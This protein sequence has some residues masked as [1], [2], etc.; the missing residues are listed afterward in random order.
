MSYGIYK[1]ALK[2][3][4]E[5]FR[6]SFYHAKK[7]ITVGSY[8]DEKAA[9]T[10]LKEALA[11]YDDPA[12]T[13]ENFRH[14]ITQVSSDKA[15]SILN[16]RDNHVYFKTP[17]YLMQGYFL[18]FLSEKQVLKFDNDDLFYYS[19]HRILSHDGH[20]YVND[21]GSQYSLFARY[22]IRNFAVK[23]VDYSFANGDSNDLRYENVIVINPY[24]GVRQLDYNGMIRYEAKIHINGYIRIGI[25][26]SMEKAAVAYNKAVDFCLSHGL[27][28]NFVKNY[29]VDLNVNEYRSIYDSV[30]LPDSLL[31]AVNTFNLRFPADVE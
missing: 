28:K 8:P 27:K 13:I 12:V 18:Y 11:L 2:D 15:V 19:T 31:T 22:G 14:S 1:T 25:F 24:N 17:I 16:H 7:H 6:V 10:A 9:E 3:G 26:H 23:G 20:L 30:S 29:V 21:Y 5:S 4:T